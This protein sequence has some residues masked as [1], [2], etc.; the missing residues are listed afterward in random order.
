LHIGR[1]YLSQCHLV[2]YAF[3]DC[4][5][6]FQAFAKPL[7]SK[8]FLGEADF[9]HCDYL[10]N[11][12]IR[13]NRNAMQG[14]LKNPCN[15]LQAL[16]QRDLTGC[17][18]VSIPQD[19]SVVWQLYVGGSR[20]YFATTSGYRSDRFGLLWQ[21]IKPEL[22]L[23]KLNSNRSE[24]ESLY[25]WQLEHNLPLTDFRRLLLSLSREALIH[26]ISY[27]NTE[28]LFEPNLCIKP[29]LIAAPL[30]DLIR[31]IV[32]HVRFWQKT[33]TFIPSPFSRIYLDRSQFKAFSDFWKN[34]NGE[35]SSL[36]EGA[37]L[38]PNISLQDVNLMVWLEVLEQKLSI[39][40]ICHQVHKEP[41]VLSACLMPLIANK[42]LQILPSATNEPL[43]HQSTPSPLIACID[44][45][46]T[47]QH[48][49]KMLLERSGFQVLGITDPASCLTSLVRQK[50]ALI[51]MDIT[52]P[53]ID[54]YELCAML[55]QSRHMRNVPI[56]M[57]T[58]R[59]G[60]IDRMRAQLA[61]ANDYITKP[62]NA[63]KLVTKVQRLL[64]NNK[65]LSNQL[66]GDIDVTIG[67][68]SSRL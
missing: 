12:L 8:V 10:L 53:E 16:S 38:L 33:H 45:S 27:T 41:H 60:I 40:E 36:E 25:E 1:Y 35:F 23:P 44:D 15:L 67:G 49:V 29:V 58:G 21:Q 46:H 47:V 6:W 61:G 17:L 7:L 63:D 11:L 34:A 26:A 59:D 50:P 51:L 48:Q 56:V 18:S 65:Y 37:G 2:G 64:Q 52:M 68:S 42:I 66:I 22:P 13:L 3:F 43:S 39:Y 30:S 57:F 9:I 20:L 54:G 24:Y 4:K 14:K 55:R 19:K 32:S 31:P 28:V 5:R 62:V